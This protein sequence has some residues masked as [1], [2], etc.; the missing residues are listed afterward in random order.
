[1]NPTM[2]TRERSILWLV[3]QF[4]GVLVFL[5]ILTHVIVNHFVSPNGLLTYDEVIRYL[6]NPWVAA[7]EIT[8]LVVVIFHSLMGL[9]S[10]LLDLNPSP[11]L[12][13]W[14][15]PALILAGIAAVTYGIWLTSIVIGRAG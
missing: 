7:M 10:V 15:D 2:E 9:R 13:R 12:M 14:I 5:F 11:K 3:K 8:F 6:G 4:T 1:M